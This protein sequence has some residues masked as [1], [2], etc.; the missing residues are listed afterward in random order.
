MLEAAI[1][2]AILATALAVVAAVVCRIWKHPAW[3]HALWILVL[4][5]LVTPPLATVS[6]PSQWFSFETRDERDADV[7]SLTESPDQSGRSSSSRELDRD[8]GADAFPVEAPIVERNTRFDS[9]SL[10]PPAGA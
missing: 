7:P 4:I 2:N 5:K 10:T 9:Q 6:L 8:E 3:A 1:G